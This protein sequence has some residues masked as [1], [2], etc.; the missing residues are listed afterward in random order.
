MARWPIAVLCFSMLAFACAG[1]EAINALS[2]TFRELNTLEQK[3]LGLRAEL[4]RLDVPVAALL[5]EH[6][7][8]TLTDEAQFREW[9]ARRAWMQEQARQE[10]RAQAAR[11]RHL[12]WRLAGITRA[13]RARS[14]DGLRFQLSAARRLQAMSEPAQSSML[15]A[16]ARCKDA[17]VE[18]VTKAAIRLGRVKDGDTYTCALA[19]LHGMCALNQVRPGR[20]ACVHVCARMCA[21]LA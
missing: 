12:E 10:L 8:R 14:I 4:A 17:S 6:D 16:W 7:S 1:E 9:I 15:P 2:A 3:S 21:C 20:Q 11:A 13:Q 19:E 5:A 18:D